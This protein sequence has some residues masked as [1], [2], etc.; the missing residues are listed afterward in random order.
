[1]SDAQNKH[2]WYFRRQ[3]KVSGPF[4]AGLISRYILLGRLEMDDELSMDRT[5]WA[6]VSEHDGLIPGVM[7]GDMND[8]FV[9][10]RLKAARRWADEREREDSLAGEGNGRKAGERRDQRE[11]DEFSHR[12]WSHRDPLGTQTDNPLLGWLILVLVICAIGA[13][14]YYVYINRTPPVQIDCAAAA[15]A[16]V[17]WSNCQLPGS[18]LTGRALP[19]AVLTNTNLAGSRLGGA[20]LHNANLSYAN[21]GQA[22]L[23]KTNLA[24]ALLLGANLR[25]ANL[26]GADLRGANLSFANLSEANLD[27]V[28]L[29]GALLHKAVWIDGRVCADNSLGDC[30]R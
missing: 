17:N 14:G 10:E 27:G 18:E 28:N 22:E 7:K 11:L 24:N 30:G 6:P 13:G 21:L 19:G 3:G 15:A 9:V 23:L 16:G 25:G 1:M 4:A 20:D 2:W 8:P 29:E 12:D 26:Q 5:I